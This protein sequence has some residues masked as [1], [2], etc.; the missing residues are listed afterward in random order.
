MFTESFVIMVGGYSAVVTIKYK[1]LKFIKVKE[2]QRLIPFIYQL[3][4]LLLQLHLCMHLLLELLLQFLQS[5][6]IF[7]YLCCITVI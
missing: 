7:V 5:I 4:R 3:F 1:V 6:M 2:L